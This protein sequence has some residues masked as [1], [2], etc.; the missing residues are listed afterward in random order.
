MKSTQR[1][2]PRFPQLL[3]AAFCLLTIPANAAAPSTN[4]SSAPSQDQQ[5]TPA[6]EVPKP[7]GIAPTEQ[8]PA[9]EASK[10]TASA[11][12]TIEVKPT[13][14][15]DTG[16]DVEA[17]QTIR[18]TAEGSLTYR[19]KK[20]TLTAQPTG[21]TRSILDVLKNYTVNQAGLGALIARIGQSA[22][23]WVVGEK[24]EGVVPLK[25]R[26]FLAVNT[27]GSEKGEG[28]F[29][30]MIDTLSAAPAPVDVTNLKL[31]SFSQELIDRVPTRVQDAQGTVGDRVNFMVIGSRERVQEA[32]ARAGWSIVDKDV[33]SAVVQTIISTLKKESYLTMPMS[34]LMLFGRT[35]DFGYAQGDPV[36]VV[37]MR[38]HFRLWQAPF[39]LE[40]HTVWAGAGTHDIGFDKDQRDGKITHKI[41]PDVDKEREF[42]AET[43]RHTG[44][45]VKTEYVTPSNPIKEAKTAHGEEFHS[46]GRT[47]VIYLLPDQQAPEGSLT[48]A[49]APPQ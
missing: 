39:D 48:P 5:A 32:F 33:Q 41:D 22:R 31:P 17:G 18:I 42:I 4:A 28:S 8:P 35:Q 43:L 45:V 36:R 15:I 9:I 29:R 23:P 11:A 12:P 44:L 2:S 38:H 10:P 49:P 34:E 1:N 25:G 19:T 47:L 14:W 3:T 30:A 7:A 6:T 20:Q 40:G 26:L 46:D 27:S 13:G 21:L 37:A 24:W 16:I